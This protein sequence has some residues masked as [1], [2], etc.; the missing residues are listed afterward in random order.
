MS[1]IEVAVWAVTISIAAGCAWAVL[2]GRPGLALGGLFAAASFSGIT[3]PLGDVGVRLE[4]PAVIVIAAALAARRPASVIALV[5]GAR[6]P[7]AL[8][9]TYLAANVASALLF[10]PDHVQSL[11]ICLWLAISL[12]AGGV[13]AVLIY[14]ARG[15]EPDRQLV[16]WVVAAACIHAVV[17]GLQVA[18]E[19]SIGSDWGLL[20]GDAPLGKA[21]GLAWEPNLLAINLAAALMFLLDPTTRARFSPRIRIGAVVLI[22]AGMALA[23]SR[24]GIV[25]LAAG[26]GVL[27]LSLAAATRSGAT[28][29]NQLRSVLGE[30]SLAFAI[31]IGGYAGLVWLGAN[32]VG[33]RPGDV[34]IVPIPEA[35]LTPIASAV[36]ASG[37]PATP[38]PGVTPDPRA[39]AAPSPS[40]SIPPHYNGSSD[41]VGLR[42][43]NLEV[44]LSD[45][46]GS[47]ILG[48]G[49][50][51]FG[52]RYVEPTCQCPAH[53][54][55]QLSATFYETGLIG[56][57]SLVLLLGL[58]IARAWQVRLSAY[59]AALV[60]LVV[61]YQ[62]TD[63]LRFA[64]NW[65]LVGAAVGLIVVAL[66]SVPGPFSRAPLDTRAPSPPHTPPT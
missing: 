28:L 26:L 63:A 51:T 18:A 59:V 62:F 55:N 42:W 19:L 7:V 25:A 16:M 39:T 60:V 24:G 8:A 36:P 10:A 9:G 40:A 6:W 56:L 32:G 17:A 57:V 21:F 12:L 48:L 15:R 41:T 44:A 53:I 65:I 27:A 31:A 50:D 3:A 46:L 11:K 5:R 38:R 23:L 1:A 33:V 2:A 34:A 61:G 43:R 47:P 30:A 4:Q 66:G 20:R 14:E 49:P 13:A 54:P 35:T 45:G 37:R 64:S 52:Q 58:V 29:R 22:S